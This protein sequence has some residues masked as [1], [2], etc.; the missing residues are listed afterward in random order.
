MSNSTAE[1]VAAG[2]T[3][4]DT[5]PA[6]AESE[7]SRDDVPTDGGGNREAAKY[8]RQLRDAEAARD[9]L[10][11]R[12]SALQRREAERLAADHLADGTDVWRDGLDLAALLDDSGDLDPAKVAASAQAARKAHPHWAA[13]RPI[14]RNPAGRGGFKSGADSGNRRPATSWHAVLNTTSGDD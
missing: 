3:P 4:V 2:D 12:L 8:R 9:S 5:D 10:S 11:E 1:A 13:P 14:K 6:P 7:S